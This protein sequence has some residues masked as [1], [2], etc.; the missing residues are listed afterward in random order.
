MEEKKRWRTNISAAHWCIP[1][2][3]YRIEKASIHL[4]KQQLHEGDSR[5]YE[6]TAWLD[7]LLLGG[8]CIPDNVE[9]D[10]RAILMLL[11]GPPGT[12]K[13]TFSIE[14]INNWAKQG[15]QTRYITT[16]A[17]A[18][19]ILDNMREILGDG[20]ADSKEVKIES[21]EWYDFISDAEKPH[22]KKECGFKVLNTFR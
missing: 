3:E 20:A 12:G 18:P 10:Q 11:T 6:G 14:L 16:E 22:D 15:K 17:H 8:L 21:R 2:L 9:N 4:G 1:E 7:E 5:K 19:W 13:S